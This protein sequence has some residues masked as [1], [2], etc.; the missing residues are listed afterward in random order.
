M[1]APR[2]ITTSMN[3]V[4]EETG[5]PIRVDSAISGPATWA[6]RTAGRSV[7]SGAS[8]A[9]KT[10]SSR[11]TMTSTANRWMRLR[12]A[13]ELCWVATCEASAPAGSRRSPGGTGTEARADSTP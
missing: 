3:W 8:T 1:P 12:V 13:R 11:P 10:R 4:M 9:R 6:T 2:T 7:S 5:T